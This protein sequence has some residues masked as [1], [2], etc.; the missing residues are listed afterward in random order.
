MTR[1]LS[2]FLLAILPF[3][4]AVPTFSFDEVPMARL[5]SLAILASFL[6]GSLFRRSLRLPSPIFTGALGSFILLAAASA[7]WAVHPDAAIPRIAFLLNLLPLVLVW[8]DLF[9]RHPDLLPSLVRSALFGATGAAL[10]TLIFFLLQFVF[11]VGTVFH[12]IVDRVLPFFLGHE[13]A[14]LVAAYPSLMVNLGGETVLRATAV[15]PDPHVAAYFFGLSGFLALGML[16]STEQ[17][18]YLYIA[19]II[20]LADLLTFS[21]GGTVGLLMGGGMYFLLSTRRYFSW[22]KNQLRLAI[23]LG[24]MLIVFFSPPVF[25]RFLTSFSFSDASGTERLALWREAVETIKENPVLGLGLGNHLAVARPLAASGTPFYA[26]NLYLDI[27]TELGLVG[28]GLFLALFAW[29]GTKVF[30]LRQSSPWAAPFGGALVL[31]LGHSLVETALFSLHVTILL[32]LIFALSL[33]LERHS[34]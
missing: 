3:Q 25:N 33:S 26:H 22:Q 5:I 13:F 1:A 16:R 18:G 9:D 2:L 29:A 8:H 28:L 12:F 30:Q 20:F 32:A 21:R 19:G 31:Y 34:A 17:R 24:A 10:V 7:L 4:F 23:V 15:F 11:G 6:I 14:A 27:A